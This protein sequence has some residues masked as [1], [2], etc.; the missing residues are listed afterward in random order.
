MNGKKKRI[1]ATMISIILL[2]ALPAVCGCQQ[3]ERES[4][5]TLPDKKLK[6]YKL[7]E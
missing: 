5:I 3:E 4:A 2:C 6:Q 7:M 1:L